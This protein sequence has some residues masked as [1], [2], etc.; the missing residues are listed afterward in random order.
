MKKLDALWT[1]S[2]RPGF[3]MLVNNFSAGI[4]GLI[5]AT[6]GFFGMGPAVETFSKGAELVVK[7]I[8]SA[9]LLPLASLFIEPAKVLFLNNAINHGILT[10]LGTSRRPQGKS[11][12]FLL[13][14]NPGPGLGLLLAYMFFGKGIAKA[15]ASG[16]AIIHFI[17]GIHE[18]Y[19]PYVLAKPK[20]IL[21]MIAGAYGLLNVLSARPAG[22]G[23]GLDHRCY[24]RPR[25]PG[26]TLS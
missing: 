23:T 19:F 21:A 11:I 25:Q 10:P 24:A 12:L 18:I 15:S 3:E 4:W 17:G 16:A 5:L 6:V 1:D 13:E 2:I 20:L 9:G 8:V 14:A 22:P 7:G 26:V